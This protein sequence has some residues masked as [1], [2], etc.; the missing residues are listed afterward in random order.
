MKCVYL[1]ALTL[2]LAF[3]AGRAS[4]AS[5]VTGDYVESRSANIFVGA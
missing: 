5:V 2:A 1:G 3:P 4:A